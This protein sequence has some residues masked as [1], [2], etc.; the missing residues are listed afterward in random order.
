MNC[1]TIWTIPLTYYKSMKTM[2]QGQI[3]F[4]RT[5]NQTITLDNVEGSPIKFNVDNRG[6]Y[7]VNYPLEV[8]DQWIRV[9]VDNDED[10]V[11]NL[12]PS[13]RA[14]FLLDSFFL[15][16]AGFLPYVKP[17][18]L[19]KYLVRE[20]HLTP[21]SIAL[22]SFQQIRNYMSTTEH[23][24]EIMQY[25]IEL[26]KPVYED[27]G[28]DDKNGTDTQKRLRAAIIEF[29]CGLY[30]KP[31]L[32]SA[33]LQYSDWKSDKKLAPNLLTSTLRYAIRQ[34]DDRTDWDFLWQ[35]YLNESSAS[36]KQTYLNALSYTTD[37]ELIKL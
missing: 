34:S 13:D 24:N 29:V 32:E 5:K 33:L 27:L 14:G 37:P 20:T 11:T 8:W 36:V 10:V 18:Q 35:K 30:H 3:Q 7:F 22:N 2:E 23:R 15:S 17:L 28:W 31:C 4:I 1:S 16:R 19:A 6:M 26:A 12:T 25:F 21:W 9:L